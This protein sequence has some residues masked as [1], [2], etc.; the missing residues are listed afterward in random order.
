MC[1]HTHG[2]AVLRYEDVGKLLRDPRWPGQPAGRPTTRLPEVFHWWEC[3]VLSCVGDDHRRLRRRAYSASSRL[4]PSSRCSRSWSISPTAS[5]TSSPGRGRCDFMAE[6]SQPDA[7]RVTCVL[8]GLHQSEWRRLADIAGDMGRAL[9][10]TFKWDVAT[11]DQS[12]GRLVLIRQPGGRAAS[13]TAGLAMIS[14]PC[15]S[16]RRRTRMRSLIDNSTT[17]RPGRIWRHRH[18]PQSAWS[19]RRACSSSIRARW[20]LLADQPELAKIK[21]GGGSDAGVS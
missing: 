16:R 8:L 19:G 13:D 10:V 12:D 20:K 2:T 4:N 9:G 21:G 6:F 1:A 18:D 7:T 15:C 5:S 17:G 3:M 11:I 14:S